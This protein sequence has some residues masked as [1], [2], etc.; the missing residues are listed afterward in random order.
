MS[1][2]VVYFSLNKRTEALFSEFVRV[3]RFQFKDS[4]RLVPVQARHVSDLIDILDSLPDVGRLTVIIDYISF[5]GVTEVYNSNARNKKYDLPTHAARQVRR[6]IMKYPEVNFLFDESGLPEDKCFIEFLFPELGKR[7]DVSRIY[8]AYHQFRNSDPEPFRSILNGE[9]NL[10]DGTNLRHAIKR[11]LYRDLK[12]SRYNFSVVQ[13]SRRDHL[14][15]CVEEEIDQNRFNSYAVYANGYRVLPVIT[16]HELQSLN[17]AAREGIIDPEICVRD[18]DLQFSD[19]V[20]QKKGNFILREVTDRNVINKLEE[21]NSDV[22]EGKIG[23]IIYQK[24]CGI[25]KEVIPI[26][27]IDR[28]RGAKF[29][30]KKG[31][32]YALKGEEVLDYWAHFLSR[33]VNGVP[34]KT[35][36]CFV[37]KG[38]DNLEFHPE[39]DNEE[40][41]WFKDGVKTQLLQGIYKPIAGI[42]E[43]LW[44]ISQFRTVSKHILDQETMEA[45]KAYAKAERARERKGESKT[46]DDDCKDQVYR[47]ITKRKDHDH[48]VP[49]DVY[50]LVKGMVMRAES[51]YQ[52]G[53]FVRAAVIATEAM[54]V[55]NGFHE[56]LMLRAYHIKAISENALSMSVLGGE[57]N[58]LKKDT[59]IRATVIKNTVC[60]I[61]YDREINMERVHLADNVLSQIYS[62]CRIV[63]KEK[64]H[65]KS[66]DVF[67][68]EMALLNDGLTFGDLGYIIKD[69]FKKM[70]RKINKI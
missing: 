38:V 49:L 43:Q 39:P 26:N 36:I 3:N 60:R 47:I 21:D 6:A 44:N 27:E 70:K 62:D 1:N 10:F 9:Y 28:I 61:L 65:F 33:T 34:K 54:E 64:E 25:W 4:F 16:S 12:C 29:D 68:R 41:N 55:M 18:Y 40:E 35:R 2:R 20:N 7:E 52:K 66:E 56:D 51:M 17:E 24:E 8:I 14:A 59:I 46:A 45:R 5:Y 23:K 19:V 50:E 67:I 32:W 42:Y 48:G 13:N 37:S 58:R 30:E 31:L 11:Y 57:E 69:F 22:E 63:C 53:K 15:I